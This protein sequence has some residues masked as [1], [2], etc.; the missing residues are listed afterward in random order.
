MIGSFIVFFCYASKLICQWHNITYSRNWID[1]KCKKT[2]IGK[3]DYLEAMDN[4]LATCCSN[5]KWFRSY[6]GAK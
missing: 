2:S 6:S 4:H 5:E 1:G 3:I